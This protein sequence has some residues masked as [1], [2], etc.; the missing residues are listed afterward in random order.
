MNS[1]R[2]ELLYIKRWKWPPTS[3]RHIWIRRC[4]LSS[5]RRRTLFSVNYN[6]QQKQT[7]HFLMFGNPAVLLEH[8]TK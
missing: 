7:K 2:T 5:V 6:N 3:T 8:K 4:M 1:R